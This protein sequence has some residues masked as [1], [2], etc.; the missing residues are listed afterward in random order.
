[1]RYQFGVLSRCLMLAA[2]LVSAAAC[3]NGASGSDPSGSKATNLSVKIINNTVNADVTTLDATVKCDGQWTAELPKEVTWARITSTDKSEDGGV[4]HL[5]LDINDTDETRKAEV[6][7]K[8][9]SLSSIG[10]FTQ[11]G[12]SS[13][14]SD[15]S[16]HLDGIGSK[17]LTL[18]T[19]SSWTASVDGGGDWLTVTPTSG[20]SGSHEITVSSTKDFLEKGSR[21][22]SIRF[23]IGGKTLTVPVNQGQTNFLESDAQRTY[24]Y[25]QAGGTLEIHT[26]NN[27]GRPEVKVDLHLPQNSAETPG[28]W[29]KHLSTKAVDEHTHTFSVSQ[30]DRTYTRTADIIFTVGELTDTVSVSQKGIDPLT[31]I[32]TVGAYDVQGENWLYRPGTDLLSRLY[33]A[34]G[35]TVSVR[36]VNADDVSVITMGGIPVDIAVGDE[37]TI[38]FSYF[39]SGKTLIQESIA[40]KV[41]KTG[42]PDSKEEQGLVWFRQ[43]DG[44]GFI[45]KK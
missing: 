19:Q 27:V 10:R 32:Y 42:D 30:N 6:T 4:I 17:T 22:A 18:T 40:A 14:L 29:L 13:V 11:K 38:A 39:Q 31:R 37:C 9:G 8:A 2:L 5:S 26:R 44:P 25:D 28:L 43:E 24:K 16:I 33:S 35:K 45:I 20:G 12:I 34:D 15:K 1:M 36:I 7:V 3:K 41:F 21:D 23:T